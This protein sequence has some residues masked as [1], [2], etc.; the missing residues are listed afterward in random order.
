LQNT[1]SSHRLSSTLTSSVRACCG[2]FFFALVLAVIYFSFP[3]ASPLGILLFAQSQ[4]TFEKKGTKR[5]ALAG[6]GKEK[7]AA[8]VMLAASADGVL[9]TPQLIFKGT[10]TRTLNRLPADVDVSYSYVEN[11]RVS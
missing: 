9:L 5:V 11:V 2:C 6:R 1:G 4:Y 3:P 8:T 10:T 7:A